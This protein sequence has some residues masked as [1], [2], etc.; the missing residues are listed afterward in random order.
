MSK[1]VHEKEKFVKGLHDSQTLR[2]SLNHTV[3][4][5]PTE[6]LRQQQVVA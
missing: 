3:K 5:I 6:G 2:E 1:K 4:G